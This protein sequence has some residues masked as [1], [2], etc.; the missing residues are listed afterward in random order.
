MLRSR[1]YGEVRFFELAR[2]VGGRYLLSSG[3]YLVDGLL[4]DTGP[5]SARS[6]FL[7]LA[8]E[9]EAAGE[10]VERILLT[11]HHEDHT[12]N[13]GLAVGRFGTVP[14]AHPQGLPLLREPEPLPLYRRLVWGASPPVEAEALGEEIATRSHTF[15]VLHTPGHAPDHV[16]LHEPREGW[17]FAGDLYLADRLKVLRADEE[18]GGILASLRELL[19]LPDCALFCQHSGRHDSHQQ[20]LAAKLDFLLGL[21]ERAV[22]H[23][24]E[25]RS[26]RDIARELG[27]RKPFWRWVSR[28]EFSGENLVRGLLR[29]AGKD[30]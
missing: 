1:R 3:V 19:R 15:R 8:D 28:G 9:L 22:M 21:Q 26:V 18:V 14:L 4:I 23:L 11:H 7:R 30:V 10:R 13:A 5:A 17:L 20:R 16:A 29:E 6:G 24:E 27:V 2:S 12:G 25:G